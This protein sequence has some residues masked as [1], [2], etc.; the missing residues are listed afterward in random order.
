MNKLEQINHLIRY[1]EA[2]EIKACR[3]G[4]VLLIQDS[5]SKVKALKAAR[6]IYNQPSNTAMHV[7]ACK[8]DPAAYGWIDTFKG[9][10]CS[11]CGELRQ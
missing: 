11:A 7:D 10:I 9:R 6:A 2:A 5:L 1:W 3:R 8:C 4:H